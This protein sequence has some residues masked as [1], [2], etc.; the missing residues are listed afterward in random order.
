MDSQ[1]NGAQFFGHRHI[2]LEGRTLVV[3]F[4]N[5]R[6]DKKKGL[7]NLCFGGTNV[8]D[9]E[10]N[11]YAPVWTFGATPPD[12]G[13]LKVNVEVPEPS[14]AIGLACGG[15]LLARLALKEAW[16]LFLLLD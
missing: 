13:L 1:G 15:F 5:R 9:E 2:V 3:V 14:I 11:F 10:G 4:R 16:I 12:I 7:R 6:N 8:W